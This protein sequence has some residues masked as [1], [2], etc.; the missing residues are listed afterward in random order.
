MPS[1]LRA[2]PIG[3]GTNSSLCAVM[4]TCACCVVAGRHVRR[5]GVFPAAVLLLGVSEALLR[6]QRDVV[7]RRWR[8]RVS[9]LSRDVPALLRPRPRGMSQLLRSSASDG[10]PSVSR[11]RRRRSSFVDTHDRRRRS[12]AGR[13]RRSRGRL[14]LAVAA[15]QTR[16]QQVSRRLSC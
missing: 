2:V 7:V 5:V 3:P 4:S 16:Y 1:H 14:S 10:R 15:V 13:G 9:S 6:G 11:R 12:A 8:C